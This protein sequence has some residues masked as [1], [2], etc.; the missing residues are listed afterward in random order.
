MS[1]EPEPATTSQVEP[2]EVVAES[3]VLE[4]ESAG[5]PTIVE[6]A[7]P[8]VEVGA[9]AESALEVA[10]ESVPESEVIAEA[11]SEPLQAIIT[12]IQAEA[13]ST[14]E[15]VPEF[16]AVAP[17]IVET[18][19]VD[20]AIQETASEIAVSTVAETGVVAGDVIVPAP[21]AV[22]ECAEVVVE[23]L[24]GGKHDGGGRRRGERT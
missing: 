8:L 18:V 15:V 20:A 11:A 13:E 10:P 24:P 21:E 1:G 4:M 19:A 2:A 22:V 16:E 6:D 7:A 9:S 3:A 14:A 12:D 23:V 5:E 17:A